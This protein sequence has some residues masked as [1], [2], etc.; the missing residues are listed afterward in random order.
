MENRTTGAF[1][2]IDAISNETVA[3]GMITGRKIADPENVPSAES[4]Q[5]VHFEASRVTPAERFLRTGHLPAVIG[6]DSVEAAYELEREL[7]ERGCLVQV[8]EPQVIERP[9]ISTAWLPLA[10]SAGLILICVAE[11]GLG[12]VRESIGADRVVEAPGL[13][14]PAI[15]RMLESRGI[16]RVRQVPLTGGE[17]I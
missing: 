13:S 2:L 6:M 16:I 12:D 1:I 8:I 10:M 7:F 9:E 5:D 14:P 15:C 4:R 11:R 17:G 3:A